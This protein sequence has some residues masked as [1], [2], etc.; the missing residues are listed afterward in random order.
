MESNCTLHSL[1]LFLEATFRFR[2][3]RAWIEQIVSHFFL[4][5]FLRIRIRSHCMHVFI[6]NRKCENNFSVPA[7][8]TLPFPL[9]RSRAIHYEE[10]EQDIRSVSVGN[11]VK[12]S[13]RVALAGFYSI[14]TYKES[15]FRLFL[16]CTY[17]LCMLGFACICGRLICVGTGS[18][19]FPFPM[20]FKG[21]N[22]I[23][24]QT[25]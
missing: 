13:P 10:R 14:G 4:S 19:V 1:F 23:Q 7:S 21:R 15:K 24:I 8:R 20:P 17:V 6:K 11:K 12:S 18:Y 3:M 9:R 22:H 16:R 2:L 5:S 25:N